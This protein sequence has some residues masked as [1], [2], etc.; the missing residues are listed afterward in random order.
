MVVIV[1]VVVVIIVFVADAVACRRR[2]TVS[3]QLQDEAPLPLAQVARSLPCV[4]VCACARAGASLISLPISRCAPRASRRRAR[5]A[6]ARASRARRL[7]RSS[8]REL[9]V[10]PPANLVE[11]AGEDRAA[12]AETR[13]A[14]GVAGDSL[15]V[16]EA[17]FPTSFPAGVR[18]PR[19]SL[20]SREANVETR[21]LRDTSARRAAAYLSPSAET[22]AATGL[23]AASSIGGRCGGR[24]PLL[25]SG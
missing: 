13:A 22:Y 18:L 14:T 5:Q 10:H 9:I 11:R 4:C 2:R 19:S 24:R 15:V 6:A 23:I 21:L 8:E 16:A 3:R 7:P 25:V 20:L 12:V 17:S 1:V